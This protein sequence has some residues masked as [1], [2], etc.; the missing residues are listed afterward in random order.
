MEC[1][2]KSSERNEGRK[3][4]GE[5]EGKKRDKMREYWEGPITKYEGR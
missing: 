4:E 5:N 1:G 3:G 2:G